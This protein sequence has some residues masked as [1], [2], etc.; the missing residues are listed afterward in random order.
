[1]NFCYNGTTTNCTP[2][3]GTLNDKNQLAAGID[4]GIYRY[5]AWSQGGSLNQEEFRWGDM[6][7]FIQRGYTGRFL[8]SRYFY[9]YLSEFHWAHADG[10]TPSDSTVNGFNWRS[11]AYPELDGSAGQPLPLVSSGRQINNSLAFSLGA[12]GD[13]LWRDSLHDHWYG[14]TDYYFMTGDESVKEAMVPNKDWY[15]N[16][17]TSSYGISASNNTGISRG[18]GV[19]LLVTSRYAT[20]LQSIGDPDASAVLAS[21]QHQFDNY[22]NVQGCESGIR[23]GDTSPTYYPRGCAPGPIATGY[24]GGT[25]SGAPGIWTPG[26]SFE[27]GN[28]QANSANNYCAW[29]T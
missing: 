9:R 23:P 13:P 8:N 5:Y 10:I 17:N 2:D 29:N 26:T 16:K 21:G 18:F 22:V 1:G 19:W 27:R 20:Y 24:V 6:L 28:H 14:M 12:S 4:L 7:K 25:G 15:L 11:R 3:R